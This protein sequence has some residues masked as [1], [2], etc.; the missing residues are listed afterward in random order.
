M[1]HQHQPHQQSPEERFPQL[2]FVS[3]TE[4][5]ELLNDPATLVVDV[6]DEQFSEGHVAGAVN[7]P[8]SS[9]SQRAA[10]LA[11]TEKARPRALFYCA[12]SVNRC[13]G[14]V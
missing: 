10:E 14:G 4:A 12:H 11:A 1:A 7:I 5:A 13:G 8:S 6:R 9:F 3:R 2:K